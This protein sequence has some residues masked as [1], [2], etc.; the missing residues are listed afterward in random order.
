M[1]YVKET[2]DD[3]FNYSWIYYMY[4]IRM[5]TS[6][7]LALNGRLSRF[8]STPFSALSSIYNLFRFFAYD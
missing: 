2:A 8:I 7:D 4:I 6:Y 5:R 1:I 3:I